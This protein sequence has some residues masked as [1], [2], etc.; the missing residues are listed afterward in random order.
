MFVW[1]LVFVWSISCIFWSKTCIFLVDDQHF[2]F[3][4]LH[5][6][7]LMTW[8]FLFDGFNFL[9]L[10]TC[11]VKLRISINRTFAVKRRVHDKLFYTYGQE[12]IDWL[13]SSNHI[14][15]HRKIA[16]FTGHCI[17]LTEKLRILSNNF[18]GF[19]EKENTIFHLMCQCLALVTKIQKF[20]IFY[21]LISLTELTN[22]K[23]VSIVSFISK[24]FW[25]PLGNV[26]SSGWILF[27]VSQWI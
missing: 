24:L 11:I 10:L 3:D 16:L 23:T 20:L 22:I 18:W 25:F 17:F 4:D 1:W 8:I 5:Y 14:T 15:S 7:C 12:W 27:M 19:Y 2:L 21:I 9:W 6:V 13:L 26:W